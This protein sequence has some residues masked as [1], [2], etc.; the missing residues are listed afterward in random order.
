MKSF[1]LIFAASV[2]FCFNS[3]SQSLKKM[4][5]SKVD[6]SKVKIAQDFALNFLTKLK[7]GGVYEF[8]GEVIEGLENQFTEDVQKTVYRQL[9]EQFGDFQSLKYAETWIQGSNSPLQIMR[10]KSDFENSSRKL[11]IRVVLNESEKVAGFWIIPWSD[12]L[13]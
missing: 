7:E 4:D 11:E 10:F 3:C 5:V 8:K 6:N 2:L 9:K 13:K 1:T 12:M